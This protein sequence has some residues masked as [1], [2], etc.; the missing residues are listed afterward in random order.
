LHKSRPLISKPELDIAFVFANELDGALSLVSVRRLHY[1]LNRTIHHIVL[2][3]IVEVGVVAL[4]HESVVGQVEVSDR[5]VRCLLDIVL[6]LEFFTFDE[7][8]FHSILLGV[9][10]PHRLLGAKE[11]LR[12][13]TVLRHLED[14][15]L[16]DA[17]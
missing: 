14:W 8:S 11:A 13:V 15:L 17:R 2:L 9:L 4:E 5:I 6:L 3:T 12:W 16:G 7:H 10:S 1:F